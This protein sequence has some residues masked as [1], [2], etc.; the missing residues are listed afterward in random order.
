LYRFAQF[1][2]QTFYTGFGFTVKVDSKPQ[3]PGVNRIPVGVF[4][5]LYL[6]QDA[7]LVA[8]RHGG[9]YC[10]RHKAEGGQVYH[11]A[12]SP[13]DQVKK[14][15]AGVYEQYENSPDKQG[16]GQV[17]IPVNPGSGVAG[18]KTRCSRAMPN[19]LNIRVM[20]ESPVF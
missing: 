12:D 18:K 9:R 14:F 4:A 10:Q 2:F 15:G 19:I 7:G 20:E 17:V 16:A 3:H 5:A 8:L 6:L 13:A 11:Q 1:F